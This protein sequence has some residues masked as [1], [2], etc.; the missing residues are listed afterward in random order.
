MKKQTI[1][2][3]INK[4]KSIFGNQLDYSKVKYV[5]SRTSVV[6]ICKKHGEFIIAPKD[7]ISYERGCGVCSGVEYNNS[8]FIEKAT[9]IHGDRF[10]YDKVVYKGIKIPV[11][12]VCK[13]HGNFTQ[14]PDKHINGTQGCPK[15][16]KSAKKDLAYVIKMGTIIHNGKYD[17]SLVQFTKMFDNKTIICPKHGEFK[18]TPANHI[19][20]KQDCPACMVGK[21]KKEEAWLNS[22][23]LPDDFLHRTVILHIDGRR[24]IVD[25][26]DSITNT[27]YEFYGDFWHGNPNLYEPTDINDGNKISFGELYKKTMTR[28]KF[29]IKH[30]YKVMSIW[31]QNFDRQRKEKL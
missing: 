5:N 25:G 12:L 2:D 6:L 16:K 4:S 29:L 14:T 10:S 9:L 13:I 1:E 11:I 23:G 27:I 31:E 21:S 22:V 7:H 30:G 28:E 3:F 19:N 20:H 17:Y 18:Q 26:F 8:T 24:F 15:C